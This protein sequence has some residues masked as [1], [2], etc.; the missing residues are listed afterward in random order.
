MKTLAALVVLLCPACAVAFTSPCGL[1]FDDSKHAEVIDFAHSLTGVCE[2]SS[3]FFVQVRPELR[4]FNP[5][6]NDW[7]KGLAHCDA[8]VIEVGS[9]LQALAHELFH[10]QQGCKSPWPAAGDLPYGDPHAG[11]AV[12]R[13]FDA[14]DVFEETVQ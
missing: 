14:I 4:W 1:H 11:W 10:V 7:V 3:G 8:H 12:H 6:A 2:N 13:I 9:N 5:A